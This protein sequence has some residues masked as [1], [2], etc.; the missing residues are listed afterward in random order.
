VQLLGAAAA[1][2]RSA[3]VPR[4][5]AERVEVDRLAATARAALGEEGFARVLARGEALPLREAIAL[6]ERSLAESA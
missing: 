6:A 2:R 4:S 5:P 3:G 1:A